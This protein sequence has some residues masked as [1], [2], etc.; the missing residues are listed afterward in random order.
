MPR[1]TKAMNTQEVTA[2]RAD[3]WK[4][5][6]VGAGTL[7]G[8]IPPKARLTTLVI[9]VTD[10]D[11]R[12]DGFKFGLSE[13]ESGNHPITGLLEVDLD[14][15]KSTD[16]DNQASFSY[17]LN[18]DYIATDGAD[19][20]GCLWFWWQCDSVATTVRVTLHVSET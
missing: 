11:S 16:P 8:S 5:I 12:A 1:L 15:H 20:P 10:K 3:T 2:A 4:A 6:K 13:D 7:G 18:I 9:Q 14:N 17:A 19:N